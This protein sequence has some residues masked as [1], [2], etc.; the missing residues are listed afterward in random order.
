MIWLALGF[1]LTAFLY[2]MAGFGGGSTYNALLVLAETDYQILP[3]IALICNII[4]VTTGVAQFLHAKRMRLADVAPLCL[5]SAP[6]AWI[7]SRIHVPETLFVG[8][9]GAT[10]LL[11]GL[12]M[13]V[14]PASTNEAAP[15]RRRLALPIAI[16]G[17]IGFLSGLV[18]IGGGIFLAPFLH[19]V[20]WG[21]A[22]EIAGAASFFILVNSLTGLAG[23]LAKL[24]DLEKLGAL[25]EYWPLPLAV[26]GG[27]VV[28]S[29]LS[30]RRLPAG[31]IKKVT[32]VLILSVA[33]RLLAKTFAA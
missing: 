9:L 23:Q 19:L 16:G 10:L 12:L 28:G 32:G 22:Q 6:A 26:V 8:L 31:I 7:G 27:G 5:L 3:S 30:A 15:G 13:F 2:S 4:V 20:R 14:N 17:G 29:F 24:G 25:A 11:A 21:R 33:I 1:L 18:G